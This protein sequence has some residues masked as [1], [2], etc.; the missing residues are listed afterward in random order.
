M[1]ALAV[2]Y[3]KDRHMTG[4]RLE[5]CRE[6]EAVLGEV[7]KGDARATETF[8]VLGG[9]E[10]RAGTPPERARWFSVRIERPQAPT[11]FP[12]DTAQKT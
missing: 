5:S 4:R 2:E 9:W 12:K 6:P 1:V 11:L 8:A 3:L 7:F 10:C